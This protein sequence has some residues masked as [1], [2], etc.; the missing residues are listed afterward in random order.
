MIG[1]AMGR[2]YPAHKLA[3]LHGD[4]AATQ[5]RILGSRRGIHQRHDKL[6]QPARIEVTGVCLLRVGSVH[7]ERLAEVARGY[8]QAVLVGRC[9]EDLHT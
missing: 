1:A 3:A 4:C 7:N 6:S 2:N 9:P 5:Q 8:L